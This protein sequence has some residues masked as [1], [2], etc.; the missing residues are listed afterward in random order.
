MGRISLYEQSKL[1]S[2]VSGYRT[3]AAPEVAAL[4]SASQSVG[5]LGQSYLA[6]KERTKKDVSGIEAQNAFNNFRADYAGTYAEMDNQ[7]KNAPSKGIDMLKGKL[8]RAKES[9]SQKYGAGLSDEARQT[10]DQMIA[11]FN[12]SDGARVE[13]WAIGAKYES[14]KRENIAALT[15]FAD[16][17]SLAETPQDF[18]KSLADIKTSADN[19]ASTFGMDK[20]KLYDSTSKLATTKHIANRMSKDA[21]ALVKDLESGA[22]SGV[23]EIQS[24]YKSIWSQAATAAREQELNDKFVGNL[25]LL[26]ARDKLAQDVSEGRFN[27]A[28]IA[29]EYSFAEDGSDEKALLGDILNREAAFG[30]VKKATPEERRLASA[31]LMAD[32]TAIGLQ[33]NLT[34]LDRVTAYKA[35]AEKADL[36]I[37]AGA[38]DTGTHKAVSRLANALNSGQ[39][40]NL[41]KTLSK[42]YEDK[43]AFKAMYKNEDD[44]MEYV[45]Y[46]GFD[47]LGKV[48]GVDLASARNAYLKNVVRAFEARYS[49][50][51]SYAEIKKQMKDPTVRDRLYR[52]IAQSV[53]DKDGKH[54][55]FDTLSRSLAEASGKPYTK[56]HEYNGKKYEVVASLGATQYIGLSQEDMNELGRGGK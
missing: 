35:L 49:D 14:V 33:K 41:D 5:Q 28:A 10:Y 56:T 48:K 55:G 36:L 46:R 51:D 38:I 24:K 2:A 18:T 4:E 15:G 19:A 34:K 26:D 7:S 12:E 22:Y 29:A 37:G 44:P 23:P 39:R 42:M 32:V 3:S 13:T 17:A 21:K 45:L 53:K 9:F 1:P 52:S 30:G 11:K 54:I 27:R 47:D 20:T 6:M 40:R 8:T 16:T 31:D 43:T 50:E 25:K